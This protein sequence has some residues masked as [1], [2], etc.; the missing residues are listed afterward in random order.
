MQSTVKCYHDIKKAFLQQV[1]NF[2]VMDAGLMGDVPE[3][4]TRNP[5]KGKDVNEIESPKDDDTCSFDEENGD[6]IPSTSTSTPKKV[7]KGVVMD[8]MNEDRISGFH[9]V[10]IARNMPLYTLEHM[11]EDVVHTSIMQN[12]GSQR[13]VPIDEHKVNIEE[14]VEVEEEVILEKQV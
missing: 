10:G 14:E 11:M 5:L 6:E 4:S 13:G 2:I 1:Q 7:K 12:Y 3:T 8:E 9:F